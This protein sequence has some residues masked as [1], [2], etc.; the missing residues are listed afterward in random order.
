M[1]APIDLALIAVP[2]Q[3]VPEVMRECGQAQIPG[4]IIISAGGKEV[5]DEGKRIE[6]EIGAV[7]QAGGIRYLGPN[8]LGILCPYTHLNAS[9]A[10]RLRQTGGA[11]PALPKRGHL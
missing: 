10:A 6:A 8:C 4:A 1:D 7:A 2:I 11:G 5:G 9:F 3:G